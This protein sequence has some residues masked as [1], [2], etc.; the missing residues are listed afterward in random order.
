L[1]AKAKG[2]AVIQRGEIKVDTIAATR[3]AAIVNWLVTHIGRM[4]LNSHTDDDIEVMWRMSG[5]DLMALDVY[6]RAAEVEVA[7]GRGDTVLTHLDA[8]TIHQL[9]REEADPAAAGRDRRRG[10]VMTFKARRSYWSVI[11]WLTRHTGLGR[12]HPELLDLAGSARPLRL[13]MM[14]QPAQTIPSERPTL[15]P[16]SST[17]KEDTGCES[18]TSN[19]SPSVRSRGSAGTIPAGFLRR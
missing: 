5:G 10:I 13:P 16:D 9:Q 15:S 1:S 6:P 7:R 11:D 17:P 18:R 19:P 12:Q 4:V 3:R 2:W 14:R 8:D